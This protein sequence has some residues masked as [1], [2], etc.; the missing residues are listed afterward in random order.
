VLFYETLAGRRPFV[1]DTP[2]ALLHKHLTEDPPNP[3]ALRPGVP[4][5]LD[6][7][8]RRLL[9]KAPEDRYAAAEDLVLDLR[10]FLN[11]A[12]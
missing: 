7:I 2:F 12:A 4:P 5:E 10:D 8:V 3:S 9:S 11:R 1:A 6:R